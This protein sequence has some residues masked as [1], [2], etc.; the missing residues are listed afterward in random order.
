MK[1]NDLFELSYFAHDLGILDCLLIW[2]AAGYRQLYTTQ[3]IIQTLYGGPNQGSSV[4]KGSVQ[5][6]P[7]PP[8][9]KAHGIFVVEIVNVFGNTD[10]PSDRHCTVCSM[11]KGEK[12]ILQVL[13]T[14]IIIYCSLDT[15]GQSITSEG[16]G[17]FYTLFHK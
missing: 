1:S 4:T 5:D 12:L 13:G 10:R 7:C 6:S 9:D 3:Y 8:Y 11:G 17:T 2:L 15:P 14:Y 16:E